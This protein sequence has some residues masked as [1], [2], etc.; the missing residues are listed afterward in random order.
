MKLATTYRILRPRVC[1][2]AI[3]AII[4]FAA[5]GAWAAEA[6]SKLPELRLTPRDARCLANNAELLLRDKGDPV[7]FYFDLCLADE[8]ARGSSRQSLPDVPKPAP[9]TSGSGKS[10]DTPIK[11]SKA[12]LR[13]ILAKKAQT[14]GFLDSDPVVLN[15]AAC[16]Q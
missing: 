13:C 4:C 1:G 12:L 3:E 6:G 14:P 15:T 5:A 11:I 9:R 8:A 16:Q 7:E 2:V 10:A